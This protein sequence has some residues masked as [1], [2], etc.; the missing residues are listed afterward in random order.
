MMTRT[1]SISLVV[2]ILIPTLEWAIV[3]AQT[4]PYENDKLIGVSPSA[5]EQLDFLNQMHQDEDS[6]NV[7]FWLVLSEIAAQLE[8]SPGEQIDASKVDQYMTTL[9]R[10]LGQFLEVFL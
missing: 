1:S 9:S 2:G 5:E 10:D 6:W 8:T 3:L 4:K 7:D